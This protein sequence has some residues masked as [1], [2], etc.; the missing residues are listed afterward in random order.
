[1]YRFPHQP[2]FLARPAN[3][4]PDFCPELSLAGR[5]RGTWRRLQIQR[6]YDEGRVDALPSRVFEET[7]TDAEIE[8]LETG[9]NPQDVGGER[10][11]RLEADEVEIARIVCRAIKKAPVV[12]LYARPMTAESGYAL[13]FVNEFGREIVDYPRHIGRPLNLGELIQL[14]SGARL[15]E[16]Y[17]PNLVWYLALG[18]ERRG[19]PVEHLIQGVTPVSGYYHPGLNAF[20]RSAFTARA[21]QGG[22]RQVLQNTVTTNSSED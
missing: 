2:P 20:Y 13:R 1:M 21:K 17:P 5:V 12:A 7:L 8:A 14:F 10:L 4:G 9:D 19:W 3:Y 16:G 22:L 11:P 15:G 18:C 6:A